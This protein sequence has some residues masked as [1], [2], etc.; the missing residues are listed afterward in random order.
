MRGN[1]DSAKAGIDAVTERE[2]DDAVGPAE[3]HGGFGS[4]LCQGMQAL[5]CASSQQDNEN[6][7]EFHD[8]VPA[9]SGWARTQGAMSRLGGAAI[10]ARPFSGTP[11]ITL[12]SGHFQRD[13]LFDLP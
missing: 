1:E 8:A 6:I 4:I 2:V 12:E 3:V 13:S 9:L 5:S 11:A 7:V 10:L